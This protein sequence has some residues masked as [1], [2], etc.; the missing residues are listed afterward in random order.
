MRKFVIGGLVGLSLIAGQAVAAGA[1]QPLSVGDRVGA[2][3]GA[4]HRAMPR[5]GHIPTPVWFALGLTTIIVFAAN[6]ENDHP[7]S[8]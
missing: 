7:R 4:S 5:F 8:A 2:V 3:Q 6:Q 1:A